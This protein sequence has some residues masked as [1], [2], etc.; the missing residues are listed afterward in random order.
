MHAPLETQLFIAGMVCH[1]GLQHMPVWLC[2]AF[3]CPFGFAYPFPSPLPLTHA[4]VG[5]TASLATVQGLEG[6]EREEVEWG[7][8]LHVVYSG[9]VATR[10]LLWDES[11][12]KIIALLSSSSAFEGDHFL[13]VRVPSHKPAFIQSTCMR[14]NN[15]LLVA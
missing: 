14:P 10:R 12:R 9:L 1:V 8:V 2:L 7:E 13:Q 3:P 15:E 11:E 5:M 6:Q 4:P